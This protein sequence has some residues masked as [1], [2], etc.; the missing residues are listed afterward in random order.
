M[1]ICKQVKAPLSLCLIHLYIVFI[2]NYDLMKSRIIHV[3]FQCSGIILKLTIK[4]CLLKLVP[5]CYARW[6]LVVDVDTIVACSISIVTSPNT[7]PPLSSVAFQ[8]PAITNTGSAPAPLSEINI[9]QDSERVAG[10][11]QEQK[12]II[13]SIRRETSRWYL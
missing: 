10:P 4:C 8:L 7:S 6:N 5:L 11:K 12:L 3:W 1:N 2:L 13:L 9:S